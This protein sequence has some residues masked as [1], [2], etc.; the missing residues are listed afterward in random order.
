MVPL[1]LPSSLLSS[2]SSLSLPD[3][4][5]HRRV[6]RSFSSTTWILRADDSAPE[7]SVGWSRELGVVASASTV[8]LRAAASTLDSPATPPVSGVGSFSWREEG[9]WVPLAFHYMSCGELRFREVLTI[10]RSG[11]SPLQVAWVSWILS[12]RRL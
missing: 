2:F 4:S 7:F 9:C 3:S 5:S 11:L 12:S 8:R 1:L 6:L 10:A